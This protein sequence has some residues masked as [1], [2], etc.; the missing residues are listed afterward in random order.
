M[1]IPEKIQKIIQEQDI[2][3]LATASK[4]G[5][6]NIIYLKFLKVCSDEQI[7]IA[8]NKFFKTRKNL[9][10]NPKI[11]FVV[12]DKKEG[13]SYQLK[14]NI[15]TIEKGPVFESAINWVKKKRSSS[16]TRPKAAILLTVKEIY[17]GAKKIT[18]K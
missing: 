3:I 1:K 6:P 9:E 4:K 2:H 11:A 12:L 17:S 16:T 14:G 10:E 8:D 15:K 18:D 13:K 5:K 7:L